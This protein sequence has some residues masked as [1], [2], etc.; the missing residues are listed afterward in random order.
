MRTKR[1]IC[2][3]R[4]RVDRGLP[5]S[6]W[7]IGYIPLRDD[8]GKTIG[9]KLDPD[10]APAV[11]LITKLFLTGT[12]YVTICHA[13][14]ASPH[15]PP[16]AERWPV[17]TIRRIMLNDVYAGYPHWNDARPSQ[18]SDHYPAIWMPDEHQ[19][20][21]RERARR[22][23]PYNHRSKSKG[24]PYYGVAFCARCD[25][26]MHR[27]HNNGIKSL[28]CANHRR[29]S[30]T[31]KPCH[32]NY[33]AERNITAAIAQYLQTLADPTAIRQE[34]DNQARPATTQTD[35]D[36][37][38]AHI[39]EITTRRHRLALTLAAGKMDPDVYRRADDELI[40]DKEKLEAAQSSLQQTIST[41]PDPDHLHEII[42]TIAPTFP[43]LAT[44][45]PYP[46]PHH[47][48]KHR[49]PRRGGKGQSHILQTNFVPATI[50]KVVDLLCSSDYGIRPHSC[51]FWFI[52]LYST[53]IST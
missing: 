40:V 23:A 4:N 15:H 1:I 27:Y 29:K 41:L 6:H 45:A 26:T 24:T 51:A 28:R 38:T 44:D 36:Q 50:I 5:A 14:N 21:I 32:Y 48:T 16:R 52:S 11:Q 25:G 34:L 8:Q 47:L 17:S 10:F 18:L 49:S 33:I 53:T 43:S 37:I 42:Q 30:V 3:M 31:G 20:I 35:L 46:N 13:L 22:A 2:G 9:A 12:S 39:N 7:P 19:H